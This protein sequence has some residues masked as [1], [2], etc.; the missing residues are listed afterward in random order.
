[1]QI[2]VLNKCSKQEPCVWANVRW[3]CVCYSPNLWIL[4]NAMQCTSPEHFAILSRE[5]HSV[6]QI[7]WRRFFWQKKMHILYSKKS[8]PFLFF[9]L[10]F[11]LFIC[12]P[13]MAAMSAASRGSTSD[14]AASDQQQRRRQQQQEESDNSRAPPSK[15]P[16]PVSR[17]CVNHYFGKKWERCAFFPGTKLVTH[18]KCI[19]QLQKGPLG[20]R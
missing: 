20:L 6:R 4:N 9:F 19:G 8:V 11:A 10:H 17:A 1:M 5:K 13:Q 7:A 15:N 3:I 16:K 2:A 14:Q 18:R 12:A